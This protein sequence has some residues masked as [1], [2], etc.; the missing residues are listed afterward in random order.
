M[1]EMWFD[2]WQ[3]CEILSLLLSVWTNSGAFPTTC[4][5][6]TK[7]AFP[8]LKRPEREAEQSPPSNAEVKN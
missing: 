2:F 3:G 5:M 4:S 1:E 7:G 8:G 6:G